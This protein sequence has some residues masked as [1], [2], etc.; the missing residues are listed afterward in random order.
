[1][2]SE[3]DGSRFRFR[4]F[5]RERVVLN[6]NVSPSHR[7]HTTVSCGGPVAR[8]TPTTARCAPAS[9]CLTSPSDSDIVAPPSERQDDLAEQATGLEQLVRPV[10]VFDGVI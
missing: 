3:M 9:T 10:N 4:Y 5:A 1:M 6:R 8:L 7:N 2:S